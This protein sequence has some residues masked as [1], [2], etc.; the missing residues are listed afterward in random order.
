[1]EKII[2]IDEKSR[3]KIIKDN[4]ILQYKIKTRNKRIAWHTDGYFAD[5]TS[6]ANEYINNAPYQA[7]QATAQIEK[8]IEVVKWS[9]DQISRILLNNKQ[10]KNPWKPN[11]RI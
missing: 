9:T 10:A 4:F 3:I 2:L 8:L 5:L 1:M 11:P 7:I 6:L